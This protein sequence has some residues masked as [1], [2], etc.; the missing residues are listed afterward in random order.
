MFS[1]DD[2]KADTDKNESNDDDSDDDDDTAISW[3]WWWHGSSAGGRT[4]N[5][6]VSMQVVGHEWLC[7]SK[8]VFIK[9][10]WGSIQVYASKY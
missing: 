2:D 8:S 1:S 5:G 10:C 4:R 3:R 6:P 7:S 9:L